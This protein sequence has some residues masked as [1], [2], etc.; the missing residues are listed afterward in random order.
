MMKENVGHKL[1]LNDSFKDHKFLSGD[2]GR[3]LDHK[4]DESEKLTGKDNTLRAGKTKTG[5]CI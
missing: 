2:H 5:F 3:Q 1:D 4:L